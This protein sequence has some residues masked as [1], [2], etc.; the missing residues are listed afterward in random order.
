MK[1]TIFSEV[2][3]EDYYRS[4]IS[5][6]DKGKIDLEI[7]D[8]RFF[9][10]CALKVYN[11]LYLL[12]YIG[13]KLFNKPLKINKD[14]KFKDITKS[15]FAYFRLLFTK[16]KIIAFFAPYSWTGI[17]LWLLK[18]LNRKMI[19]L[20][21]WPYWDGTRSV[22]KNNFIKNMFW[23]SF[24]QKQNIVT[25]SNHA[26]KQLSKY[27]KN[28]VQIPHSVDTLTFKPGNKIKKFTVLYVGRLIEEKGILDILKIAKELSY[29]EFRFAG[30]GPLEN[31]IKNVNL[32]NVKFL[33]YVKDRKKVALL[34][35]NSNVFILNSYAIPKW[36]ELYGIVLL[37]ALASGTPVIATDCVG[38]KE[39]IKN[40]FGFLIK[41]KDTKALKD[42]IL[43]LYNKRDLISKMGKN[44]RKFVEKNYKTEII[45][46]KWYELLKNT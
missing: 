2:P 7:I 14:V 26:L 35:S 44:G 21:S 10:L 39:I 11:S 19:Y 34:F 43:F 3:T 27:T 8:S 31:K 45:S 46:E 17:Y 30:S 23:T 25:I 40:N 9:Y 42:K 18:R 13:N 32:K 33:G 20:T 6:R 24:L 38:P 36:E 5:L 29:I 22:Y 28:I 16:R 37:E 4:I 1:I 12:R 15:F 41:Q